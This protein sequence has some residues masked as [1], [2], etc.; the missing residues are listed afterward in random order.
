MHYASYHYFHLSLSST[1][2]PSTY[3]YTHTHIHT[4][5]HTY[6]HKLIDSLTLLFFTI[7]LSLIKIA[8][9]SKDGT[10]SWS[11]VT[12]SGL[13]CHRTIEGASAVLKSVGWRRAGVELVCGG[14]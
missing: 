9:V 4:H 12:P 3:T 8:T 13:V 1:L 11:S 14:E 6:T 10:V 7:R 2:S 5:I